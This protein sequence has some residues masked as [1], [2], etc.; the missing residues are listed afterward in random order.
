LLREAIVGWI[1]FDSRF[2]ESDL[3]LAAGKYLFVCQHFETTCK[4]IVMWLCLS[5]ALND[6]QFQFLSDEHKDYVEQL[7]GLFLGQSIQ[8]LRQVFGGGLKDE[9]I[10][11]LRDAK[12]S[13]NF[14]CHECL[15]DLVYAPFGRQYQFDWDISLH[16]TNIA[17]LAK[18]DYLVSRWA[19]EFHEKDSGAF[20]DQDSYVASIER[21]VFNDGD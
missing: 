19:Y 11:A 5:K 2:E 14:I 7:L 21:W 17:R 9:N 13:R 15:L 10:A 16:R 3:L 12:D 6:S 8:R 1:I 4:D 18:G 20:M